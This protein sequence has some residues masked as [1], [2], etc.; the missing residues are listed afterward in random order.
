[1]RAGTSSTVPHVPHSG[2]RPNHFAVE[3]RHSEHRYC[4]RTLATMTTLSARC[5]NPVDACG[6]SGYSGARPSYGV[7]SPAEIGTATVAVPDFAKVKVKL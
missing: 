4:E 7:G 5:D 2:Q 1:V 3:W 6:V